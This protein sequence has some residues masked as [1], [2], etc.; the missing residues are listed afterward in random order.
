M[1]KEPVG[2]NEDLASALIRG[3]V[4]DEFVALP[5]QLQGEFIMWVDA[6]AG[7]DN[8]TRR[9]RTLVGL[10]RKEAGLPGLKDDAKDD[11]NGGGS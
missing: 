10:L 9:L 8:R 4:W 6:A 7:I 3:G 2:L 11:A 5:A 1:S